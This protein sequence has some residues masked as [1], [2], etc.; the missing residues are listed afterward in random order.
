MKKILICLLSIAACV[1]AN[2]Q[3]YTPVLPEAAAMI[4]RA[5]GRDALPE[6]EMKFANTTIKIH[7]TAA[8]EEHGS[9][10]LYLYDTFTGSVEQL[11]PKV[12]RDLLTY[13]FEQVATGRARISLG[14]GHLAPITNPGETIEAWLDLE[15][16]QHHL[17]D[18][19]E[20]QYVYYGNGDFKNENNLLASLPNSGN[21]NERNLSHMTHGV[22]V[23]VKSV[24]NYVD[25][26]MERIFEDNAAVDT[27]GLPGAVAE[28]LRMDNVTMGVRAI[29]EMRNYLSLYGFKENNKIVDNVDK[30]TPLKA[31]N[32][33][34]LR[35]LYG[36]DFPNSIPSLAMV[37]GTSSL[38]EGSGWMQWGGAYTALKKAQEREPL[39]TEDI[40]AVDNSTP[41]LKE[42]FEHVR[43]SVE[44]QYDSAMGSGTFTIHDTPTYA[45][46]TKV[47]EAI[48]AKYPGKVV[49]VDFWATWCSP[50]LAAM[51]TI[52]PLKPWMKEH[53]VVSIYISTE[54]SP[55]TQWTLSLPDIGGEHYYLTKEEWNAVMA[56]YGFRGI[57]AYRQ[58]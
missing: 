25:D 6:P 22:R 36:I 35:L 17:N 12:E 24:Q 7:L 26:V 40:A 51:R 58:C 23:P 32:L 13:T 54:S 19:P 1:A 21:F 43:K 34:N 38:A 14:N 50:C 15:A 48:V 10:I 44:E 56:L 11:E 57:P 55:K 33:N 46:T 30:L 5:A 16:L 2:A 27:M 39:T 53:D 9:P 47:V 42:L 41:Y 18:D 52:K 4:N 31:L 28:V 29:V 49:F 3:N 8:H 20:I 37:P 45:D